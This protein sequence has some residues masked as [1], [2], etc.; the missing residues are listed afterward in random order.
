M[1]GLNKTASKNSDFLAGGTENDTLNSGTFTDVTLEGGG[2]DDVFVI[3]GNKSTTVIGNPE[4][5]DTVRVS[6]S[7]DLR[8]EKISSIENLVYTGTA[9]VSLTGNGGAGSIIGGAGA[10]TLSDGGSGDPMIGGTTLM[11]GAGNDRY[12]VSQSNFDNSYDAAGTLILETLNGGIDTVESTADFTLEN[13]ANVENLILTGSAVLGVGNS[14]GNLIVGSDISNT[15]LGLHGSDTIVGGDGDDVIYGVLDIDKLG[16]IG[17]G[18]DLA[19]GQSG[20]S[21]VY[22][23]ADGSMIMSMGVSG[24]IEQGNPSFTKVGKTGVRDTTFGTSGYLMLAD[25]LGTPEETGIGWEASQ[26]QILSDGKFLVPVWNT[27]LEAQGYARLTAAGKIDTTFGVNGYFYAKNS[28]GNGETLL[29]QF[30]N[31]ADGFIVAKSLDAGGTKFQLISKEGKSVGTPT[32]ISSNY[33]FS[34]LDWNPNVQVQGAKGVVIQGESGDGK[35]VLV[36]INSSGVLDTTFGLS[37]YLALSAGSGSAAYDY[38]EASIEVRSNG[39]YVT[40]VRVTTN[41]QTSQAVSSYSAEGK[42]PTV[43]VFSPN[44]D[45]L[46]VKVLSDGRIVEVINNPNGISQPG[47]LNTQFRIYAANGQTSVL[48][49]VL[50]GFD[51]SGE[52]SEPEFSMNFE[53]LIVAQSA[54]VVL[55]GRAQDMMSATSIPVLMRLNGDGTLDTTFG[56]NGYFTAPKSASDQQYDY[57]NLK[58]SV[59]ADGKL[60][61]TGIM[62]NAISGESAVIA[63]LTADGKYD[64]TFGFN[65]VLASQPTYF[66]NPEQRPHFE[67]LNNGSFLL[68]QTEFGAIVTLYTKDGKVDANFGSDTLGADSLVGGAGND[69]LVSGAG[70]TTMVGGEGDDTY[71]VNNIG[72]VIRETADG[73]EDTVLTS[74]SY[75]L[76]AGVENLVYT[77]LGGA[78]LKGNSLENHISGG[79]ATIYAGAGDMVSGTGGANL[80]ILES[81]NVEVWGNSGGNDTIQ[82][83]LSLSLGVENIHD[84]NNLIY[85]GT[86]GATLAGNG[87]PGVIIGGVGADT[88]FGGGMGFMENPMQQGATT[89]MGGAGNDRYFVSESNLGTVGSNSYYTAGTVIVESLNG[90]T[91]TVDSTADFTLENLANV[92]NLVFNKEDWTEA[93]FGAGNSLANLIVGN[94]KGNMLVGL[95]GS[96]TIVGGTGDDVIYGAQ[97]FETLGTIGLANFIMPN[98][99]SIGSNV[100]TTVDGSLVL[101]G[102]V[103]EGNATFVKVGKN[104]VV[105]STFGNNGRISVS[106]SDIFGNGANSGVNATNAVMTPLSDGKFLV[107]GL[108]IE[109]IGGGMQEGYARLNASGNLDATF[110]NSGLLMPSNT[111]GDGEK[112]LAQFGNPTDGILV[113]KT[114]DAGGTKFQLFSK[115]GKAVGTPT[116]IS[117]TY[118]FTDLE[119]NPNVQVQGTKGVVIQ[120]EK[121]SDG[122][123]VLVRITTSGVVDTTFG[124]NG[125]MTLSGGTGS[126]TYDYSDALFDVRADAIFV[127]NVKTEGPTSSEAVM[128]FS[129]DGKTPA[130]VTFPST[131]D[132]RDVKVL[133]DGRIVAVLNKTVGETAGT[134]YR[135]YAAN[136]LTSVLSPVLSGF[137]FSGQN[138]GP[139]F[140]M[141][142]EPLMVSQSGGKVVLEGVK[143]L[144]DSPYGSDMQ[145]P[146]LCRLNADG[147]LDTT[148]GTNGYFTGLP[149][150]SSIDSKLKIN[151]LSDGKFLFTYESTGSDSIQNNFKALIIARVTA[152]G[153]FDPAFGKNEYGS[154]GT[155]SISNS[156][157][158]PNYR[159]YFEILNNGSIL[160]VKDSGDASPVL[161]LF[162]KDGKPDTS[163]GSDTLGADSLVGGSG[164]DKLVSGAGLTTMVGGEGDDTYVVNNSAD[165][166][167]ETANGGLD[168]VI[169]SVSYTLAA[170]V[171]NLIYEGP[172]GATLKGNS[173]ENFISGGNATIYAGAGDMV[174]GSG[175]SNLYILE[176]ENVEVWGNSGGNDTIQAA[177]GLNLSSEKIHDV[178]NLIY[179]GTLGAA[180]TGI[181]GAGVIIGGAGAD[182]LSAGEPN[183]ENPAQLGATTLIGGVG[184]DRYI[185]SDSDV[186]IVEA[187]LGGNDTVESAS[188]YTLSGGVENLI[189][190]G[191]AAIGVGSSINNS[192]TGNSLANTLDGGLG[193]D[194]L[195]GGEGDD[196]YIVDNA[197][198]VAVE[199]VSLSGGNDTVESAASYTLSGGVENLILKGAA[200]IGVGSSIGN[201]I[202]GNLLANT[203]DGGL[204]N[205]TLSGEGGNDF[206]IVDSALDVVLESNSSLGGNDTI[207]CGVSYTLGGGV[208]NLMLRGTAAIGVGNSF[209][210]IITGTSLANTL[211]G[212]LGNDT[213]SGGDGND[214]YIVDSALDVIAESALPAG[215]ND[216]VESNSN[217]TLSGGVENV[218]LKGAA[219]IGVGSSINNIITGNSLANTLDGGLGNDTLSGGEGNDYYIVD[220]ALDVVV[221]SVSPSGGNDTVESAASYTLSGGIENLVLK[222]SATIGMGSSINNAIT[223]N[224]L[225]NTLDGGLGDDTLSGEGGNDFYIVDSALDVVLESNSSLGGNDTINSGVN[226]TLGGGVENLMLRG[227]AAIGV[228]NSLNNI[229]T[230]TSLANTLDGGL[231]N[232]TLSGEGGNDYYIVDSALDV[233]FEGATSLGGNDTVESTAS[234][235]L[236]GGVEN[237][238]LKGTA[239]IGVGSS[240]NNAITGNSLSNT[241]DG[242]LGNDTLSGEGGNDFYIV[243][244]ALDVV[245]ESMSSLGGNDT[246]SSTANY[247]LSGGV[248]NLMLRG[249]AA[250]GVGNSLNNIIT[251]NSLANTL[252][253]GLGNDS[254][255]GEGGND[256]YIIDSINDIVVETAAAGTDSVLSNT[257]GYM[258]AGNAEVLILGNEVASGTGNSLANTLIGNASNNT[259]NGGEGNDS[260]VGGAGSDYYIIDSLSDT[261]IEGV[262]VGID[263]VLANITG[264]TLSGNT[265]VLMLGNA[266]A[267]GTGNSLDNLLIGNS[268]SNSL[269]GGLGNDSLQGASFGNIAQKDT[270]TGG[271]GI[272]AFILGNGVGCFY[273]DGDT[274]T[275]GTANFAYIVDFNASQDKL[276]LSGVA[277]DYTFVASDTGV[278]GLT[279]SGFYGLFREQ[280]VADELVAILKSANSTTLNL[281]NTITNAQ[282]IA[283]S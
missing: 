279:G 123:P 231:G 193:N 68:S 252:D 145:F 135:I 190:K 72:N 227:T 12:M 182:T 84:V 224:S 147:S 157:T 184:N 9:G 76:A 185:V 25:A 186:V 112:F 282:F 210:N 126:T 250:I 97:A 89:L 248:E 281:A 23:L 172:G 187:S 102:G 35:P 278:V 265:E 259:L 202:G 41:E 65:G 270:L 111:V 59:L 134:Q 18:F 128:K 167:R 269:F 261:I 257:S 81:E 13:V 75:T 108:M 15:L 48:S 66:E 161:S 20:S 162:T 195:F 165:V 221:E 114:L 132:I 8:D 198:D 233:V 44:D 263:S 173:L 21:S 150:P 40:G 11:G 230:G 225:A 105:D 242:G 19:N 266:I 124:T 1:P 229:I 247:T 203:L 113:A 80:Y 27:E 226:Y 164:N 64:A 217:Y 92:E 236:S 94:D 153:K 222:G 220:N 51:F 122:N 96:D 244:S 235:T 98:G 38:S 121:A 87:G 77:G 154:Y 216:T 251:G 131:D 37:G 109:D 58:I 206:Y 130:T 69:K 138:S 14:L 149:Y 33:D 152:D 55:E 71:V 240:I 249:T 79:N 34:K 127:T 104:G 36:R 283:K 5:N 118:D 110:G 273:D 208:E 26:V 234:Y 238:L 171:E 52:N 163:F 237:L 211:D 280:G 28:V 180:L 213:L 60:L 85:T 2:G 17:L 212:G 144:A 63:R 188:N 205:D 148:F 49:P 201:F 16:T 106:L 209:N 183:P 120:G 214:Y 82:S 119:W 136:G 78:T 54:K 70:L 83:A 175:G 156:S 267:S 50:S 133:S 57:S 239:A 39:I 4:G 271:D 7:F 45:V 215:G 88:L 170:G 253:G 6:T 67:I 177:F 223:G 91:D 191:A 264:Y 139:E 275:S 243:D 241:L 194:T 207:N 86:L 107:S 218:V 160:L 93:R 42:T 200:A 196:Y 159:E 245:I 103:W 30:G 199:S 256:F 254:L 115:E 204:G 181:G 10:D 62:Q 61:I 90:G 116:L 53:P 228:G 260:L 142:Y 101:Q 117:S 125:Y 140:S 151:T 143:Y 166:I 73:G 255:S 169:T 219:A 137:D 56:V 197:L 43:V 189:L 176:S 31:G 95:Q 277:S 262:S 100:Y 155:I 168:T 192:I 74:V 22:T 272:D 268:I 46:N 178:N 258:L 3:P 99:Q 246:I 24:G 146:T 29:A 47:D 32:L 276:V 129:V 232:D 179:T 174:S 274:L 141:N 158:N